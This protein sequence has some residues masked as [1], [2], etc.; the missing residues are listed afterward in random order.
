MPTKFS[1]FDLANPALP[2]ELFGLQGGKNV[3]TGVIDPVCMDANGLIEITSV[4]CT[5]IVA[6]SVDC[7]LINNATPIT[8][9]NINSY[10]A[11]YLAAN[12]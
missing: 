5:D 10:I 1:Q 8:A 12:P 4:D 3:R 11:A 7:N 9:A 2:L 6:V